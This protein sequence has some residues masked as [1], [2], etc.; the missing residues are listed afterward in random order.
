MA[1]NVLNVRRWTLEVSIVARDAVQDLG[2]KIDKN[3]AAEIAIQP[4]VPEKV[5][6]EPL[7]QVDIEW[8]FQGGRKVYKSSILGT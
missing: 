8:C 2:I 4:P 6:I 3:S 5:P 1:L 7:E